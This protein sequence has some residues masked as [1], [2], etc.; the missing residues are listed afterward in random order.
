MLIGKNPLNEAP[1]WF[2]KNI[3]N[4]PEECS[5]SVNGAEI[6]YFVWGDRSKKPLLLLHGYNAH[7]FWWDHIAPALTE[8]HC[9]VALD[10]SGMGESA[11]R[12]EYSQ[13]IFV[14]DVKGCLLYTSPS[15]RDL[16][17]SRMPS[18]A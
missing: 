12:E 1:E 9:V 8:R 18:S 2:V 14:E 17:L 15:P 11:R 13:E 5:V 6:K 4:R 10:F 7:S 16:D 3:E